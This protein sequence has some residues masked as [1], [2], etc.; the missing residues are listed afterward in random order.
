MIFCYEN[1]IHFRFSESQY[2]E[3]SKCVIHCLTKCKKNQ[4]IKFEEN[5]F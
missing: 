4:I 5:S 3:N 2:D 1:L